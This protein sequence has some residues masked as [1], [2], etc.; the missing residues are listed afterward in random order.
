MEH[1][2]AKLLIDGAT[3]VAAAVLAWV[4]WQLVKVTR[5]HAQHA[6]KLAEA[7]DRLAEH[8]ATLAAAAEKLGV[9]LESQGNALIYVADESALISA[10]ASKRAGGGDYLDDLTRFIEER[11][12]VRR[13]TVG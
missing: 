4:T 2:F 8:G 1:D 13:R 5:Y 12:S 7:S 10:I 9:I 11:L 6:A 3:F